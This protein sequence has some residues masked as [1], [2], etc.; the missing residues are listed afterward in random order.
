MRKFYALFAV[1]MI[2]ALALG[3]CKTPAPAEVPATEPEK[4]EAPA[5]VTEA[6]AEAP[7]EK[8]E[9]APAEP[10]DPW[11]D[12][13][14]AKNIVFWHQHT[15][16][17]E[18]SLK[19]I[20]DE[21]NKTNEWGITVEPILAGSYS[22]I[23]TKMNAIL[24]T[25]EVPDVV[26]GYQNQIATY[27]LADAVFNMDE[28]INHPVYGIS[29]EDQKD[30]FPS[31]FAQDVYPLYDNSRLGLAPNRSMEVLYYNAAWLK[32]LGYDAPPQ[33][34]EQFRE[35]A[36]KAAETPFSG[37]KVDAPSKGYEL[38]IDTSR[39]ASW[40][41]A[42]GGDIYDAATNRFTMDSDAAVEAM[43]FIQ[44]LFN[45]GCATLV[46]EPYGDQ[47]DFG[48]G[49]LL[50]TVGSSSGL[51]YYEDVVE[52]EGKN[53]KGAFEW[54]VAPLPYTGTEPAQNIYGASVSIPKSTPERELAAWLF[55]RYYTSPDAQA[56]WA[57]ASQYFPVRASVAE[58]MEG[59]FNE[60]PS[61][62]TAFEL[63]K[64]GKFEPAVP[65]YDFVRVEVNNVMA[66][67]VGDPTSDVKA[68]L[69]ALNEFA[70]QT[71]DE[72]LA[73]IAK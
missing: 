46:P 73:T 61:Y 27:Q 12:V 71:L 56:K 52:T 62:K 7:A 20:I 14:P 28:L 5:V 19:E 44:G 32:E 31:F 13:T 21:F 33:T 64:Y 59:F 38:S 17:R 23:F 25:P 55:I 4:T 11:A 58:K 50:F 43:T 15:K 70:N 49:T 48:N 30:F 60:H 69:T 18:E 65:G 42:F 57:E 53:G 72:Q 36:C 39:F 41:Y 67:I 37:A 68:Q 47:T 51:T 54:S 22:E 1:L 45:D 24:N 16:A 26:V 3:A 6:P 9:E 35:M 40:T 2:A 34:P 8:T 29:E 10:A 63:L 66:A